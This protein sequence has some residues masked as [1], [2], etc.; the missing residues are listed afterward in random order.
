MQ[1]ISPFTHVPK[2]LVSEFSAIP[3]ISLIVIAF[4]LM[5]V[6]FIGVQYCSI[7]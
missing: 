2:V 7:G 1:D 6:G 4:V 5:G 3:V